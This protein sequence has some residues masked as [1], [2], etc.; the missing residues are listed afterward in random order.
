MSDIYNNNLINNSKEYQSILK[1]K[2]TYLKCV[3][4]KNYETFNTLDNNESFSDDN[5]LHQNIKINVDSFL[6]EEEKAFKMLPES[7]NIVKEFIY[8]TLM[9]RVNCKIKQLE[10]LK[11]TNNYDNNIP[12]FSIE[13][14]FNTFNLNNVL[15]NELNNNNSDCNDSTKYYTAITVIDSFNNHNI[16]SKSDNKILI[17]SSKGYVYLVDLG[18][19]KLIDKVCINK[20]L[21]KPMISEEKSFRVD[22]IKSSTIKYYDIYLSRIAVCLRGSSEI[23]IFSFN[24]THSIITK[25]FVI[26]LEDYADKLIPNKL[27]SIT[28]DN[29][30]NKKDNK[31]ENKKENKESIKDNKSLY[32][33]PSD[34][35]ISKDSYFINISTYNST[36]IVFKFIDIPLDKQKNIHNTNDEQNSNDKSNQVQYLKYIANIDINIERDSNLLNNEPQKTS[37]DTYKKENNNLNNKTDKTNKKGN[38]KDIKLND[39]NK[40]DYDSE[41]ELLDYNRYNIITK[42][43]NYNNDISALQPKSNNCIFCEFIQK[44]NIFEDQEYLGFSSIII[45]SGVYIGFYNTTVVKYISLENEI[46]KQMKSV[47]KISKV[48]SAFEYSEEDK[49]N[50]SSKLTKNDKKFYSLLKEKCEIYNNNVLP[51]VS[52]KTNAITFN[53]KNKD[54]ND[55]IIESKLLSLQIVMISRISCLSYTRQFN[56]KCNFLAFGLKTGSILIWDCELHCDKIFLEIL[57][58]KIEITH[59]TINENYVMSCSLDSKVFVHNLLNNG[60]LVYEAYNNPFM[61][62]PIKEVRQINIIMQIIAYFN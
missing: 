23:V 38:T 50:I 20:H 49:F 57:N 39:K 58:N 45:T 29:K 40:D 37:N 46:S 21:T 28:Q 11:Q 18:S 52:L 48:K 9:Y 44:K 59:V 56:K 5:L 62:Y 17:G 35:F 10:Y 12:D 41:K 3:K 42:F 14:Y 43:D 31:K 25:D 2:N 26:N 4:K 36:S 51:N 33:I 30:D 1:H 61:N 55:E 24:H 54:K 53:D 8:F 27:I 7:L 13:K 34:I 47:F 15:K 22:I 6:N 60:I 32:L 16:K 19:N